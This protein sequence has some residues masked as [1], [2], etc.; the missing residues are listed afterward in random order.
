MGLGRL[1]SPS[2]R[3]EV[4][5]KTLPVTSS[6]LR[7]VNHALRRSASAQQTQLPPQLEMQYTTYPRRWDHPGGIWGH[8]H[9]KTNVHVLIQSHPHPQSSIFRYTH[10]VY[11]PTCLCLGCEVDWF[12]ASGVRGQRN[13]T[14]R[15][16]FSGFSHWELNT[17]ETSNFLFG[18]YQSRVD[19]LF[20][21]SLQA[22]PR[23]H[24][25]K[26]C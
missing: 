1:L 23:K 14:T 2:G 4:F 3:E 25:K 22:C 26:K 9:K 17:T 10:T 19:P 11:K 5:Q 24:L 20:P 12:V 21:K 8:T 7:T 18:K 6:P 13:F 15:G 16:G